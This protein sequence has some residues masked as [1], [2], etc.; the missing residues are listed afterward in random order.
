MTPPVLSHKLLLTTLSIP[1]LTLL[2]TTYL[3]NAPLSA[4]K[5]RTILTS[6]T[7]SPSCSSSY[8]V[9]KIVNP[10]N[11][12]SMTDSRSIHLSKREIGLMGDEEILARLL[13]GFFGGW[14]FAPEEGLI[15]VLRWAGRKLISVGFEGEYPIFI[16]SFFIRRWRMTDFGR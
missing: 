1:T 2:L 5:T 14:I 16:N 4:S 12:V 10:R 11:H 13:K 8:S 7:L 9:R 3:Y 6:D 15:T